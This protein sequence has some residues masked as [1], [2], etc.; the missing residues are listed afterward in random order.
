[1]RPV[2]R[3]NRVRR[4]WS[5]KERFVSQEWKTS[6]RPSGEY[7]GPASSVPESAVRIRLRFVARSTVTMSRLIHHAR[8]GAEI[9][10]QRELA[11]IRRDVEIVGLRLPRRQREAGSGERI[12]TAAGR[13]VAY[14][15]VRLATIGEPMVPE[16]EFRALGDVRLD[17]GVLALLLP[18]RLLRVGPEIG[19]HPADERDPPAVGKPLD[20][21]TAGGECRQPA[22]LAAVRRDQIDLRLVVVLA[23]RGE[24]DRVAGGRPS[25]DRCPCRHSVSRRGFAADFPWLP[26]GNSHN[27]VLLSFFAM[28]KLVTAAQARAPSG[29]SVGAAMRFSA[30]NASTVSGGLRRVPPATRRVLARERAGM[31]KSLWVQWGVA[32]LPSALLPARASARHIST[33]H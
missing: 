10:G 19:P 24:R 26:V 16:A 13:D 25:S 14:E 8:L 12:A 18:F 31:G 30:H 20:R 5:L 21:G 7:D 29:D 28:S 2:R 1:M 6:A 33:N 32:I 22:R 15:H 4:P 17:L 9:R 11:A 3:S 23:L 27:S